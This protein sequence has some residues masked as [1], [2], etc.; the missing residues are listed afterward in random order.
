MFEYISEYS[1]QIG[2]VVAILVVLG[3]GY[4]LINRTEE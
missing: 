4:Y 1:T 2:M 3:L